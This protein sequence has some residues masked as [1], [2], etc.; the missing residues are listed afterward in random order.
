MLIYLSNVK[1]HHDHIKIQIEG[2]CPRLY[3][4]MDLG[5][6]SEIYISNKFLSNDNVAG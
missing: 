5:T 3:D 6:D 4:S 2:C 1:T